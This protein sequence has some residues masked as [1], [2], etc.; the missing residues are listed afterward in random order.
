MRKNNRVVMFL[1]AFAVVMGSGLAVAAVTSPDS[2]YGSGGGFW[3]FSADLDAPLAEFA[4]DTEDDV[5]EK[6]DRV[7]SE[8]DKETVEEVPLKEEFSF[9]EKEDD[10]ESDVVKEEDKEEH[11]ED[12]KSDE[13]KDVETWIEILSP[14]E[15]QVFE[16]KSVV[17]EGEAEAGAKV[18]AGDYQAD[19]TESGGWRIVLF[20]SPG[21][22][23]V[24]FKAIDPAGN[25]ADD[26][27]TVKLA[28]EAPKEE[29]KNH[30]FTLN[31]KHHESRE[32][33]EKFYGTGNPGVGILAQSEYGTEDARI[34][35]NG[36]WYLPIEFHGLTQTTEFPITITT[37]EG[38]SGTYW[39]TYVKAS[40][41]FTVNQKYSES[42]EPFEK[43]Y[44][45]GNPGVG[46]LAQS[47]YGTE[48]ARIGE[49]GEWHLPLEFSGLTETTTFPITI[50]TTEGFSGTY[51][52]TYVAKTHEFTAN[53]QYGS[54]SEEVPYDVFWGTAAPGSVVEIW[55]P[56]GS[57]RLEVGESGQWEKKVFFESAPFNETFEVSV[58]DSNGNVK[59]F[60]FIRLE[61]GEK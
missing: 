20:L 22:Q 1:T 26:S 53:Q 61:G 46:I 44:G 38:F 21:S 19:V 25:I 8:K 37:T 56:Y 6:S 9:V 16:D 11:E 31:Q 49:G 10:H 41:E 30:E 57:A 4:D 43:F 23:T 33:F 24:K 35:E 2:G 58:G 42:H 54:C 51:W 3:P 50:T 18:Y 28:T 27:V 29:P 52:F 39:F 17:F 13:P 55:S 14:T 12:V 45:T 32:P 47:E 7:E 15:G 59:T 5:S 34:G 40:H 48:D 60:S 36:E